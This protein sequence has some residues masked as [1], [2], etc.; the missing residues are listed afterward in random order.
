MQV[1]CPKC[2]ARYLVPDDKIGPNGRRV[3]CVRC[4]EEWRTEAAPPPSPDVPQAEPAPEAP[5]NSAAAAD[6]ETPAAAVPPHV[7]PPSRANPVRVDPVPRDRSPVPIVP[8]RMRPWLGWL[9]LGLW[10][11]A[12]VAGFFLGSEKIRSVWPASSKIYDAIGMSSSAKPAAAPDG[13]AAVD[14]N[15]VQPNG[16]KPTGADANVPKSKPVEAKGGL[17]SSRLTHEW[18]ASASG[19][20]DLKVTGQVT[21]VA[22]AERPD[23]YIRVRL[24]DQQGGIVRDKRQKIGGGDFAPGES[25][26][27]TIIFADPGEAVAKAIPAIEDAR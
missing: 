9:V 16:T 1:A 24:L 5:S 20:Y 21:N 18:M 11:L 15:A 22:G 7:D 25:R 27:F 14:P 2:N 19:G 17:E 12:V 10:V 6:A 13:R 8:K 3:R 23:A 4:D 26:Q